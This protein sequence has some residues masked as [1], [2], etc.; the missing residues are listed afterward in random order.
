MPSNSS[1]KRPVIVRAYKI[2]ELIRILIITVNMNHKSINSVLS[3]PTTID[4][5]LEGIHNIEMIT[6]DT[7]IVLMLSDTNA[8]HSNLKFSNKF[9]RFEPE[10]YDV[11]F[12][13]N[14]NKPGRRQNMTTREPRAYNRRVC[15]VVSASSTAS[16]VN[17]STFYCNL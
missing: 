5:F 16:E 9:E 15:I 8:Y 12:K 3:L 1:M 17:R 13:L 6:S 10:S 4:D 7:V 2:T 14:L 11:N